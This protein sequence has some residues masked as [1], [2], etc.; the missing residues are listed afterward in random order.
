MFLKTPMGAFGIYMFIYFLNKNNATSCFIYENEEKRKIR[1]FNDFRFP[2]L[3]K[4]SK[5]ISFFV[6]RVSLSF[7]LC[8]VWIEVRK[9][10]NEIR[11]IKLRENREKS[12]TK[13]HIIKFTTPVNPFY[14][15]I[16]TSISFW[17]MSYVGVLYKKI[18]TFSF[19]HFC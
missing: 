5:L 14:I 11:K 16:C 8:Y 1:C 10:V 3:S 4:V 6:F 18:L 9:I 12:H 13:T 2:N 17:C 15:L 7:S 19:I